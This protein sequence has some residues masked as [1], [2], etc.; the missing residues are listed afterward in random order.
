MASG[1]VRDCGRAVWSKSQTLYKYEQLFV[2]KLV[3][4]TVPTNLVGGG[5]DVG[6]YSF[7]PFVSVVSFFVTPLIIEAQLQLLRGH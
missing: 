6:C 1:T 2:N 4:I 7:K 3:S 5:I